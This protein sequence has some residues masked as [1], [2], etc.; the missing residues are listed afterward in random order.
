MP[1][2]EQVWQQIR[3]IASL[4]PVIHTLS[5]KVPNKII[6][7]DED[8]IF[9]V[10][11]RTDREREVEKKMFQMFWEVLEQ[12]GQMVQ[13][14]VPYPLHGRIIMAILARLPYVEYSLKPQTLYLMQKRTHEIG[15]IRERQ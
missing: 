12:Q 4:S 9:V 14:D 2:F 7:V 10:S 15:T 11:E 8:A 13:E 3:E 5:Q 6:H 1:K